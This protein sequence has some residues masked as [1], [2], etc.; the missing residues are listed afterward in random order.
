[1]LLWACHLKSVA[2]CITFNRTVAKVKVTK[3]KILKVEYYHKKR[4]DTI[5]YHTVIYSLIHLI[6]YFLSRW[7]H[8]IKIK[9]AQATLFCKSLL[10]AVVF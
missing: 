2:T 10:K 6:T 9:T 4:S 8:F 5:D 7:Q 1:M 3:H